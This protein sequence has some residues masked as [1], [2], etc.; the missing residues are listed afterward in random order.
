VILVGGYQAATGCTG[1][2]RIGARTMMSFALARFPGMANGGIY[3]CRRIPG[4]SAYS[5]HAEG[6]ADDIMTGTGTPTL[7]SRFL[8]EQMRVFSAQLGIQG[9]IH[10]RRCWFS[11]TGREWDTYHGS[12]PHVNHIHTELTRD[13]SNKDL[14]A[15]FR[16]VLIGPSVDGNIAEPRLVLGQPAPEDAV[17]EVQGRLRAHGWDI[18]ADG[19]YGAHTVSAVRRFQ[20][21]AGIGVDGI[22][23]PIT[24]GRLR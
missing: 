13:A 19:R 16:H 12:N 4:S 23:G 24:R 5:I 20:A 11:N 1:S 6:R 14:S 8:S 18:A 7:A 3:D 15:V 22:V 17:T 21:L 10:N 2:A 9:I